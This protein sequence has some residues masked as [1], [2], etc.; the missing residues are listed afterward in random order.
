[1][2][3]N[4]PLILVILFVLK[5]LV[6]DWLLQNN[7]MALHKGEF[8]HPAGI[9]HALINGVGTAVVI[10]I[11]VPAAGFAIAVWLGVVDMLSHYVI[12]STKA[13]ISRVYKIEPSQ[14]VYWKILAFDQTLHWV[15]Y[16]AFMFFIGSLGVVCWPFVL[17]II[18]L[19]VIGGCISFLSARTAIRR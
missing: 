19:L 13:D 1:M 4:V 8:L 18:T 14:S 3:V 6:C 9:I 16:V 15:M 17:L 10:A 11:A 7:E 2:N 12:D 5:H